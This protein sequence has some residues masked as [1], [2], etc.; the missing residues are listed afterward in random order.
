MKYLFTALVSVLIVIA[1]LIPGPNLPDVGIGGLDK[2][3]HISMF[4]TWAIAVRHDFNRSNFRFVLVFVIGMCFSLSTEV[5]QVFV[6]GRTFDW[7][8]VVADGVGLLAGLALSKT[9]L[10]LLARLIG[11]KMI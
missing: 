11:S 9:I 8:D 1:V 10:N 3:V 7:Y 2:I 4:G 6:E 5:L